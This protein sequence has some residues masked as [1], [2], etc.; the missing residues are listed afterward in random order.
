ME[1]DIF[2]TFCMVYLVL[3]VQQSL[4]I[5]HS[6]PLF[7]RLSHFASDL[8][9]FAPDNSVHRASNVAPQA[10]LFLKVTRA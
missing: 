1:A 9:I 10:H 4:Y 2:V 8:K 7:L 5:E 3:S 6:W